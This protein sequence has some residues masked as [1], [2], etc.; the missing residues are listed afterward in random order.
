MAFESV[1]RALSAIYT[2]LT[3]AA[4][5]LL[6]GIVL[7]RLLGRLALR[8]LRELEVDSLLKI[9][10]VKMPLSELASS[11]VS[12]AM[13]FVFI[14]LALDRLHLAT[15]MFNVAAAVL[16][17]AL[18]A[19]VLLGVKDLVPNALAGLRLHLGGHVRPGD[20]IRARDIEG[21]VVSIGMLDTLMETKEGDSI[22]MPNSLL[23][24]DTVLRKKRSDGLKK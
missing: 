2:D 12:H 14:V 23:L 22:T 17:V 20:T 1:V 7:G 9:T 21:K 18:V 15:V 16:I 8:L 10:G 13:Y 4:V 6:F 19:S 5:L 3:V 24:L 11:A